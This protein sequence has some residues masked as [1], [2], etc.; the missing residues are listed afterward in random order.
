MSGAKDHEVR[1]WGYGGGVDA[2]APTCLAV[3]T[4]HVAAVSAVAL[5]KRI[6]AGVRLLLVNLMEGVF[7]L[8]I[9]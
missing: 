4:G 2:A 7:Y 5:S 9:V 1:V 6:A 3:G 8:K